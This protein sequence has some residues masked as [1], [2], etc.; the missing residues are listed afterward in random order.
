[1]NSQ[2]PVSVAA[3]QRICTD[4]ATRIKGLGYTG[5]CGYNQILY[6]TESQSKALLSWLVQKLP[7]SEEEITEESLGPNALLN[8]RKI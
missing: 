8:K 3:R 6:P 5:E 7:R 1:L 2:L 4:V